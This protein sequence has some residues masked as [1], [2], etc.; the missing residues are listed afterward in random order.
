MTEVIMRYDGS[1]E[2]SHNLER[3]GELVRC[4]ECVRRKRFGSSYVC[5]WAEY[6]PTDEKYCCMG[7]KE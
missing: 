3:V 4:R 6:E 1:S 7:E 2:D 5:E